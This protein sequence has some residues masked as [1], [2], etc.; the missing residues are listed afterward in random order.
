M[1]HSRSLAVSGVVAA[2]LLCACG[3]RDPALASCS[4]GNQYGCM[5]WGRK[6][7][8]GEGVEKDVEKGLMYVR[9]ACDRG[10]TEACALM[11]MI[12]HQGDGVKADFGL[13]ESFFKHSCNQGD[14][15]GC[16]TLAMVHLNGMGTKRDPE[17]AKP[18]LEKACTLKDEDACAVWSMLDE[19]ERGDQ[20]SCGGLE[21]IRAKALAGYRGP[22]P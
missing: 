9:D 11:G 15:V 6:L 20:P 12:Y 10:A 19:C 5:E 7:V 14:A 1:L 21:E 16:L 4:D 2:I 3:E 13:A 8:Y 22:T 17:A 18:L